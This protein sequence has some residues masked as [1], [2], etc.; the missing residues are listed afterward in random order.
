MPVQKK[1][2]TEARNIFTWHILLQ[3]KNLEGFSRV[4]ATG[5]G[6]GLDRGEARISEGDSRYSRRTKPAG[7][8]W[9][10]RSAPAREVWGRKDQ[11]QSPSENFSKFRAAT[12]LDINTELWENDIKV[13]TL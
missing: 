6:R 2:F 12:L 9:G 13:S 3:A 4:N 1:R 10:A 7:Y 11:R 8:K 5:G